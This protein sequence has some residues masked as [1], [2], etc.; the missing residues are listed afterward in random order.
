M[1]LVLTA[2]AAYAPALAQDA[3]SVRIEPSSPDTAA[4]GPLDRIEVIAPDTTAAPPPVLSRWDKPRWVMLRSLVIPGWGQLHNR[5]WLKAAAV[6]GLETWMGSRLLEDE[7]EL[8]NLLRE[9]E[10][11]L[12]VD[13]PRYLEAVG[14]YNSL[15]DQTV[16]RRWLMGFIVTYALLDAYVDAHFIHFQLDRGRDPALPEGVEP[17]SGGRVGLRWTF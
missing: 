7:R 1:A 14:R 13:E 12:G 17:P 6:A 9:A 10:A 3:D 2:L 8:E 4:A 5:S 16:G 15:L 11:L